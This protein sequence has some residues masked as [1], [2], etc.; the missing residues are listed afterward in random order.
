MNANAG[1]SF[2]ARGFSIDSLFGGSGIHGIP[3]G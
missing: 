2:H 1:G 3:L